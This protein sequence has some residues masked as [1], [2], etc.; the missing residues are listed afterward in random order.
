MKIITVD[1]PVFEFDEKDYSVRDY[2]FK[3]YCEFQKEIDKKIKKG[4]THMFFLSTTNMHGDD[5]NIG[6][7]RLP[8]DEVIAQPIIWVRCRFIISKTPD[9]L[10]ETIKKTK[11][12]FK[13]TS[14]KGIELK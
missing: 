4:A 12:F 3:D 13:D 7:T 8:N 11:E 2:M 5:Y 10:P 14:L 6:I 9:N 1:K